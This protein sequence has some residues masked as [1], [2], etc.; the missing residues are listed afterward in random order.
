MLEKYRHCDPR[1]RVLDHPDN[2]GPSAARNTGAQAAQ[3]AYIVQLDSDDLLEPTAVEKWVWFLES[4]SE[5]AFTKGYSVGFGAQEYLWQKGFHN[6]K[7][8]LEENI[9][10]VTS[11][12][13][14]AVYTAVGGFR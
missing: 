2:C 13:R 14:T 3:T 11:M 12:I 7:D 4:Y 6:G 8:F 10:A 5:Y 9:V 1:I